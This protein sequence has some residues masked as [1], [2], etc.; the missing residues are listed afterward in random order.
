MESVALQLNTLKNLYIVEMVR[1]KDVP[2]SDL[3]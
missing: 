3:S 2:G 1:G